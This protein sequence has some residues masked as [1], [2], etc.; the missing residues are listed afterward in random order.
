MKREEFFGKKD[1]LQ[2]QIQIPHSARSIVVIFGDKYGNYKINGTI[3][4]SPDGQNWYKMKEYRDLRRTAPYICLTVEP[5]HH[6]MVR[7]NLSVEGGK[8]QDIYTTSES[9]QRIK[10]EI[11]EEKKPKKGFLEQITDLVKAYTTLLVVLLVVLFIAFV[12]FLLFKFGV[13]KL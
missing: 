13:L 5:D 7:T 9:C 11:M 2:T 12:V 1:T 10:R 8:F 6:K 4:Y 3:E